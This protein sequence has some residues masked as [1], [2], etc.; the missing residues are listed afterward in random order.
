[1]KTSSAAD[2]SQVAERDPR[3]RLPHDLQFG[4]EGTA[5]VQCDGSEVTFTIELDGLQ[6]STFYEVILERGRRKL[7]V[8][9]ILAVS[10]D[11]VST[12]TI[13]TREVKLRK[14]DFLTVRPDQFHNPEVDQPPFRAAL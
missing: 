8:G 10:T 3:F 1:V 13:D 11:S 14:Y 5:T 4:G 2:C 6:T 7:D 12:V 9:T